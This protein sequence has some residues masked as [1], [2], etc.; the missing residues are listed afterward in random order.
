MPVSST[1][2]PVFASCNVSIA[3]LRSEPK[4]SA[5][6]TS[7][8]LFGERVTILRHHTDRDWTLVRGEW[9]NY[10]GWCKTGQLTAISKK[11]FLKDRRIICLNQNCFINTIQASIW[12]PMNAEVSGIKKGRLT[13]GGTEGVFKGKRV[14]LKKASGNAE[15]TI[16]AAFKYLSAPYLWG[17]KTQAGIDCSGLVQMA[18][19]Q[20][21]FRMPRDAAQQAMKGEEVHFL[22]ETKPGDLAFFD[23]A[24]GK[25]V[26]VGILLS[27]DTV[28]HATDSSGC[29]V[30][31]KIDT[32]G[33]ISLALRKRT[34]HLRMLRRVTPVNQT[35]TSDFN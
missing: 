3:A 13:V 15:A 34:H 6:Q 27:P 35:L 26:H 23:N 12:L 21:A 25:I 19:K 22:A 5:E 14:D 29:V 10:E 1:A 8:L 17:G 16:D 11:S 33:I 7:Q 24:E 20:I 30:C 31:D 9:D 4:H 28:I 32:E 18:F 2:K